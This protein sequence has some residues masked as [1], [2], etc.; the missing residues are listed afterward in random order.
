MIDLK[1]V[2]LPDDHPLMVDYMPQVAPGVIYNGRH[3][4]WRVYE[5]FVAHEILLEALGLPHRA[6]HTY[7]LPGEVTRLAHEA[8]IRIEEG[9]RFTRGANQELDQAYQKLAKAFPN[10]EA[11][12]TLFLLSDQAAQRI[13][14]LEKRL[15][16]VE[17]ELRHMQRQKAPTWVDRATRE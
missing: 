3:V 5:L 10:G 11:E 12:P 8:Q 15:F 17:A 6:P 13:I 9:D 1:P 14:E 2:V 16:N 4:D 7:P